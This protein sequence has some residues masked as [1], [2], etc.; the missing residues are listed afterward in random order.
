MQPGK[1][2]LSL[3]LMDERTE[4]LDIPIARRLFVPHP[5]V[6][7]RVELSRAADLLRSSMV[8]PLATLDKECQLKTYPQAIRALPVCLHRWRHFMSSDTIRS[9]S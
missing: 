9:R 4:H 7:F 1:I 2:N 6:R 5:L 3:E 8:L